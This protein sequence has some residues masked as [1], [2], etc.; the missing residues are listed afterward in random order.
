[1]GLSFGFL[2]A[3]ADLIEN[4]QRYELYSILLQ[5]ILQSQLLNFHANIAVE[6][7]DVIPI[8]ILNYFFLRWNGQY[9]D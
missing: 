2:F 3:T 9:S 6:F 8:I 7:M 4:T 1:M 5:F